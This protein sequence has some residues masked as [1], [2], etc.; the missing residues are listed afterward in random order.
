MA[1]ATRSTLTKPAALT[2]DEPVEA[3]KVLYPPH[4]Y[5]DLSYDKD[6]WTCPITGLTVEKNLDA[7]IEQRKKLNEACERSR[8][9]RLDFMAACQKSF[10]LWL[11]MTGWTYRQHEIMAD[12]SRRP[13][14]CAEMPFITWPVQDKAAT[15]LIQCIATGED[16]LFDKS[17][18]M[19]VT[20]LCVAVNTW[21]SRFSR[22]FTCKVL[23]RK[24]EEVDESGEQL[25]IKGNSDTLLWKFR[26]LLDRQPHWMKI[27]REDGWKRIGIPE[28]GAMIRGESTNKHAARG[29][30]PKVGF[31]DECSV[32]EDLEAIERSSHS[33]CGMRIWNATPVGPGAYSNLRFSGKVKVIE[34]GWWDH[35]EKGAMGRHLRQE[36]GR[37]VWHGP[38]REHALNTTSKKTVAQNLDLDHERSGN[39]F[40]D[41]QVINRHK[42]TSASIVPTTQGVIESVLSGDDLDQE[43]R[44]CGMDHGFESYDLSGDVLR[45]GELWQYRAVPGG[46]LRI[47]CPMV[48][49]DYGK[50]KPRVRGG[51]AM[52]I[53]ISNGTGATPSCIS[54]FVR[55]TGEQVFE[56][57]SS[58]V[59][60][61]QLARVACMLGY[62]FK[63]SNRAALL[64][65]E[66]NG[67][68][69]QFSVALKRLDYQWL[70][71]YIRHTQE[72][73]QETDLIGW[74]NNRESNSHICGLLR[75]A[76]EHDAI[77]VRSPE[78]LS[79]AELY[80]YT[81][82]GA[83]ESAKRVTSERG[84]RES[85]GDIWRSV[86]VAWEALQTVPYVPLDKPKVV[87]TTVEAQLQ[88]W[89]ENKEA[90]Q[91]EGAKSLI[92]RMAGM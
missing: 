13:I 43:I 17:R 91:A 76:L 6:L 30:R 69:A 62:M 15:T 20:W 9:A 18:E 31:F 83:I 5:H 73:A 23:S 14:E 8:T 37:T 11:N 89:A 87:D 42:A 16:V 82:N 79:E 34:V 32:Y 66:T 88:E 90:E 24:E 78:A 92:D 44:R 63:G 25:G 60:P 7:N 1:T 49:D 65:F 38:F 52:G 86:L 12:G 39:N 59:D 75:D 80:V 48:R 10:L 68:G 81:E 64:A 72:M 28:T 22:D 36:D 4:A 57:T 46:P 2:T 67:P 27:P 19:G 53:D 41:L 74:V 51:V 50:L 21:L 61:S 54:G 45:R 40:F 84:A 85:H 26:Y 56:W 58:T 33:A 55:E 35:P 29:T 70:F 71:H 47:W 77:I 3:A